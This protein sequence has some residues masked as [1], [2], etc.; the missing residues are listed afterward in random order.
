MDSAPLWLAESL[1]SGPLIRFPLHVCFSEVGGWYLCSSV[2]LLLCWERESKRLEAQEIKWNNVI[3][4]LK[5]QARASLVQ[6]LD[7]SSL[8]M[9]LLICD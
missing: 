1:R 9:L 5:A 6:L 8:I 4:A 2:L 7:E 3:H